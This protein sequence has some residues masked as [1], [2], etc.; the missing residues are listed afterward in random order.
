MST[1]EDESPSTSDMDGVTNSTVQVSHL[2]P[3]H[4]REAAKTNAEYGE[5]SEKVRVLY[6]TVAFGEEIG[7]RTQI[8]RELQ[9]V[10][11]KKD[12]KRAEIREAQAELENLERREVRLEDQ[13]SSL[14]SK[15]DKFEGA[16]EMIEQQ[17]Y[18]GT[19]IFPEFGA[20]QKAAGLAGSEPEQVIQ[21][22]KQRNPGVPD[23]AFQSMAAARRR[24]EGCTEEEARSE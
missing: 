13:K 24:W 3:E 10:R 12:K 19:H 6:E 8:E 1:E 23:Y 20:V 14:S 22:L 2:V 7:Q 4:V 11:E 17:L 15:E 9:S 5:L 18:D 16:I 21:R